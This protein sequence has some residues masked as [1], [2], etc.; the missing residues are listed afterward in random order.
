MIVM[1][2][3][4]VIAFHH[5]LIIECNQ[6]NQFWN[7]MGTDTLVLIIL[8]IL[9]IL[10]I[11]EFTQILLKDNGEKLRNKLGKII[12]ERIFIYKLRYICGKDKIMNSKD[13][14]QYYNIL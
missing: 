12:Q 2:L 4:T 3:N 7:S 6:D 1:L 5:I 9:S 14:N 11:I 13:S 8:S 10:L